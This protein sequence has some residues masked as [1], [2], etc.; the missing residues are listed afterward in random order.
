MLKTKI[1]GWLKDRIWR[2]SLLS[3]RQTESKCKTHPRL[4]LM[5]HGRR[6]CLIVAE[7]V[8]THPFFPESTHGLNFTAFLAVGYSHMPDLVS[9]RWAE[10]Y[11]PPQ[12]WPISTSEAQSSTFFFSILSLIGWRG[13]QTGRRGWRPKTEQVQVLLWVGDLDSPL[14]TPVQTELGCDWKMI[15]SILI[16]WDFGVVCYRI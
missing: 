15:F 13:S 3:M 1:A 7:P 11:G 12:D 14:P 16:N 10:R 4:N 6:F 8:G 9:A 5:S 2:E